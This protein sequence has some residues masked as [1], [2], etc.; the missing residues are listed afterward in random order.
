MFHTNPPSLQEIQKQVGVIQETLAVVNCRIVGLY[1]FRRILCLRDR[2]GIMSYLTLGKEK[3]VFPESDTHNCDKT[4][5][6]Y[7][8]YGGFSFAIIQPELFRLIV[9]YKP[10]IKI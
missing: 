5:I 6:I 7:I 9:L 3:G 2:N 10:N 1:F 8:K 4:P